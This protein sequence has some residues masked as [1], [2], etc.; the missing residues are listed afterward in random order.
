[1][2]SP[3]GCRP[4]AANGKVF[5]VAP[6]QYMTAL[7]AITGNII[8]RSKS[9]N[10]RVR[11]SIGLSGDNSFIYVKTTDGKLFGISTSA[12]EMQTQLNLN[13][14][15]GYDICAAPVVE[16]NGVIYVP[17]NSGIV[18]AVDRQ[19]GKLLWKHKVCNS[20]VNSI[21]PLENNKL[22]VSTADGKISCLQFN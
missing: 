12:L 20:N 14:Q 4:I 19:T 22:V 6:D 3:A 1:M 21:M 18:S 2:F 17:S 7:D 8:W 5:I 15:L 11:E 13:L 16:N 10:I 9:P